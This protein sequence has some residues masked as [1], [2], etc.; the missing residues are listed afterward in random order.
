MLGY[1]HWHEAT[2][3]NDWSHLF[4]DG[5]YGNPMWT[6][7]LANQ[8]HCDSPNESHLTPKNRINHESQYRFLPDRMTLG[9]ESF[10][11]TTNAIGGCRVSFGV[12]QK[13]ADQTQNTATAPFISASTS[14]DNLNTDSA[15]L[16]GSSTGLTPTGETTFKAS[17]SLGGSKD[18][19]IA[20]N[21]RGYQRGDIYRFGVQIY[22]LN[23][24]PG[25]VLWIGDIQ[26]PEQ[27]DVLR[28]LNI[29]NKDTVDVEILA[30]QDYEI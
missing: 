25:N 10:N 5:N 15:Q 30:H 21:K 8:R 18:P 19:H 24:A 7:C 20:G 2:S 27:H 28:M 4:Y 16:M 1:S 23:G 11:Y 17:M 22:D 6:T 26:T 14:G 3:T 12:E 29:K 9:A 13:V